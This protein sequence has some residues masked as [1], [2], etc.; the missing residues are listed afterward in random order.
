MGINQLQLLAQ[1]TL[2]LAHLVITALQIVVYLLFGIDVQVSALGIIQQHGQCRCSLIFLDSI[3][4]V[5]HQPPLAVLRILG[6]VNIPVDAVRWSGSV[7]LM[8]GFH[9]PVQVFVIPYLVWIYLNGIHLL[10]TL[11][12]TYAP[13]GIGTVLT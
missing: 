1:L 12:W 2:G 8:V 4:V 3:P 10:G 6:I 7:R 5:A 11:Y 9:A 13:I